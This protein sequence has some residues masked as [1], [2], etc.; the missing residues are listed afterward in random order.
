MLGA[1]F[2]DMVGSTYEFHPT[3]DYD[4]QLLTP[5]TRFTD[6]T[7]MTLAVAKAIMDTYGEED[8][9]VKEAVV[10]NMQHYGRKYHDAGY[11]GRFYYWLDEKDPQP[12]NSYGNGS[13]MRV[14]SVG[15][16]FP[17]LDYTLHMAKLTAEVTHNHEEGIKGAQAIAAAMYLARKG[18]D[19]E[20][21]KDYIAN[22]FR[23][24]LD[25]TL[26]DIRPDYAF[27]VTC[28]GS[29]PEAIIAFLES[30]SYE[31]TIRKAVSLGG[32]ADTQAC[33][34]G[35]I[36][37]AYYG[38]VPESFKQE[39]LNRLPADL[40]QIAEDFEVFQKDPTG[41]SGIH[42]ICGGME[43]IPIVPDESY[44]PWIEEEE[45]EE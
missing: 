35:A 30:D 23:Y 13:G 9:V 29:I 22:T 3:K 39:T 6:D 32:D 5:D 1:I 38:D 7:V 25:R 33:I 20:F 2:G 36:A 44:M 4:F 40:S 27:D 12:Y 45:L 43:L 26:D 14:S 10:K 31:D 18:R 21:I 24:N 16:V 8:D 15:W 19:K 41:I 42:W 11:G 17:S 28:Q 37:E 34:A